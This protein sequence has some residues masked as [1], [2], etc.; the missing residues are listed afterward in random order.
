MKHFLCLAVLLAVQE[1]AFPCSV[2]E[3]GVTEKDKSTI[4][5]K[6]N[7]LRKLIANGQVE[8]Q[9]RG[10]NLKRM[11]WD[12]Y[13]AGQA[14]NIANMCKFKHSPVSD[15]RWSVGQNLYIQPTIGVQKGTDWNAAVQWWFDE[16][17]M[18]TYTTDYQFDEKTG[19]YTQVVWANTSHVGCGY[20]YYPDGDR[21]E[22]LYVCNYGPGGNV[23]HGLIYKVGDHGCENLC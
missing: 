13:L 7:A 21:N 4:L 10:V 20:T 18:Y 1:Y 16:H 2:Y 3:Y 14:Q 12:D 17:P 9:P 6:H 22:K 15:A 19:H 5:N 23:D 8:N 11:I